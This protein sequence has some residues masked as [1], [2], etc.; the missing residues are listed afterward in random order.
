[1]ALTI[2]DTIILALPALE[3]CLFLLTTETVI[4]RSINQF[5]CKAT[6]F[7]MYYGG[8]M[9]SWI[10]V[11]VS[12]ARALGI[13]MPLRSRTWRNKTAV[14]YIIIISIV[15]FIVDLPFLI[16]GHRYSITVEPSVYQ[17]LTELLKDL[18]ITGF[19]DIAGLNET[20]NNNKS[21]SATDESSFEFAYCVMRQGSI[22]E[23]GSLLRPILIDLI[24]YFAVPFCVITVCN[25]LIV[26]KLIQSLRSLNVDDRSQTNMK[27]SRMYT[28]AIRIFILS[29]VHFVSAGPVAVVEVMKS[30]SVDNEVMFVQNKTLYRFFNL[31]FYLNSGS[32]FLLYCLFGKEFRKDLTDMIKLK[33]KKAR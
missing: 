21:I 11:G 5:M 30:V 24:L 4:L 8:H 25:S 16:D 22:Y 23:K 3:L 15:F 10:V 26:A 20:Q 17:N 29:T 28:L 12:C 18:N 32:N 13:W 1:M 9:S 33:P 2:C 31:L 7:L 27:Q 14:T 19:D 6:M